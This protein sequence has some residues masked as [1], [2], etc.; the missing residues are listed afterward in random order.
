ML[1]LKPLFV[2]YITYITLML[3]WKPFTLVF[4]DDLKPEVFV[5]LCREFSHLQPHI[6]YKNV[7][8]KRKNRHF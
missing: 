3:H 8:E 4:E 5:S 1:C 7:L 6:N 2:T